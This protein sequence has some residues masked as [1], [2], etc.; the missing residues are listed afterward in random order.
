MTDTEKTASAFEGESVENGSHSSPE[1]SVHGVS[2][3]LVVISL[4]SA[5]VLWGLDGTIVADIQATFVNDSHFSG[6]TG[7]ELGG[8]LPGCRCYSVVM[9]SFPQ[10]FPRN[11]ILMGYVGAKCIAISMPNGS[12][13]SAFLCSKSDPLYV[14]QRH[15][16][17]PLSLAEPSAA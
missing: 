13:A 2:W 8:L 4:I 16:N 14:V 15:R 5:T 17:L 10:L 1:R 11:E 7:L 3:L 6:Q 9:V 12:S